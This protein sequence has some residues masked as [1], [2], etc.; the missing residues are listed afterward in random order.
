[1]EARALLGRNNEATQAGASAYA[2]CAGFLSSMARSRPP[3]SI[4]RPVSNSGRV[5]G[6][7]AG[8]ALRELA[9]EEGAAERRPS[10]YRGFGFGRRPSKAETLT[11]R[12]S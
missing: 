6:R 12:G 5:T 2:T 8:V 10:N 3:F 7:G 4:L 1:M 9:Q 11:S